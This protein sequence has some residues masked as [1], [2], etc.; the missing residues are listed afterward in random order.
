M[1]GSGFLQSVS[2]TVL[3]PWL[4][5]S[6]QWIRATLLDVFLAEKFQSKRED[7]CYGPHDE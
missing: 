1:I 7:D 6:R 4:D 3:H 2:E 5:R